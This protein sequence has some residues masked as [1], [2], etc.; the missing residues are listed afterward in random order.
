MGLPSIAW[1]AQLPEE[2]DRAYVRLHRRK[3]R[4][5]GFVVPDMVWVPGGDVMVVSDRARKAL[6]E[7]RIRSPLDSCND[8]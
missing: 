2:V 6:D 1:A 8:T 4:K 7:V 5:S 3:K